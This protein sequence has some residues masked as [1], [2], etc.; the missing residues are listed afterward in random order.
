MKSFLFSLF[1]LLLIICTS[2]F[3]Q[4]TVIDSVV[5]KQCNVYGDDGP[6]HTTTIDSFNV[7]GFIMS[8][9]MF[10]SLYNSTY[11]YNYYY[12][13]TNK[14]LLIQYGYW[15]NGIYTHSLD[16]S[17]LYDINDSLINHSDINITYPTLSRRTLYTYDLTNHIMT[18]TRQSYSSI[19]IDE[20]IVVDSLDN[21]NRILRED[22]FDS[23]GIQLNLY[24]TKWYTYLP[25]DSIDFYYQTLYASGHDSSI[26]VHTYDTNS[27]LTRIQ[28][29]RWDSGTS[30]FSL[31]QEYWATYYDS[32]QRI[33]AKSAAWFYDTAYWDVWDTTYYVYNNLNQLTITRTDYHSPSAGNSAAYTYYPGTNDVD[34]LHTCRWG[35][36]SGTCSDCKLEYLSLILGEQNQTEQNFIVF[37]NPASH[38][39]QIIFSENVE[40]EIAVSIIDLESRTVLQKIIHK[41]S[42]STSLSDI[43]LPNGI[44]FIRIRT[45][46]KQFTQK[47]IINN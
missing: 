12:S 8:S 32:T 22:W 40:E 47:L 43:N 34:S 45:D 39:L 37:P 2:S 10:D 29:N 25:N 18:T 4:N 30:S 7:D 36:S 44:Y 26:F 23:N 5:V 1:C 9:T 46:K 11:A 16:E 33:I 21:N 42:Y 38:Q 24:S 19:W 20:S 28:Q 41:E 31:P 27:N 14:I 13:N 15:N 17:F 35:Q 3:A 6:T